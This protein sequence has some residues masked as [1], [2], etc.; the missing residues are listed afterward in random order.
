M[1]LQRGYSSHLWGMELYSDIECEFKVRSAVVS[2]ITNKECLFLIHS[3]AFFFQ[4]IGD[5]LPHAREWFSVDIV[6]GRS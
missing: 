3:D 4:D 1:Y 6:G 5:G 2:S